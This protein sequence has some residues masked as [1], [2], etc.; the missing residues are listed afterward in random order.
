MSKPPLHE[1]VV[2]TEATQWKGRPDY[3]LEFKLDPTTTPP[4]WK[5]VVGPDGDGFDCFAVRMENSIDFLPFL[6]LLHDWETPV[7][8]E[9]VY[10]VRLLTH[11]EARGM[12]RKY[13]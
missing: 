3:R 8:T 11:T 10:Y 1:E 4:T 5:E 9:G 6:W 2:K 7:P 13:E 12:P